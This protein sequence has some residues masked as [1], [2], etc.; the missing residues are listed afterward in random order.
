MQKL[1]IRSRAPVT[2]N[3]IS[4]EARSIHFNFTSKFNTLQLSSEI[5]RLQETVESLSKT[6]T[7]INTK[8]ALAEQDHME[9]IVMLQNQVCELKAQFLQFQGQTLQKQ[10][11]QNYQIQQL[12]QSLQQRADDYIVVD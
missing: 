3:N 10:T 12:Q 6:V 2:S 11:E 5:S 4:D 7:T 9:N 8:H 1:W